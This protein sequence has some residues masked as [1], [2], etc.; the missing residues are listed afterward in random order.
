VTSAT[1]LAA[2][3]L[4]GL[5]RLTLG[6]GFLLAVASGVLALVVGSAQRRRTL[7]VLAIL[8][9]SPKQRA[10]FLWT[11][12]RA[13]VVAGVTAGLLAGGLVAAQL[14]KVL[15]GI[16][17]PAPEHPSVPLVLLGTLVGVV[18]TGSAVTTAISGRVLGRVE[19]ARLRDF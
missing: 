9:A 11:E 8:G 12:A 10:G 6:F 2:S 1:G 5:A 4:G 7:V 3:N 17:D 19:P 15:T 16:F 18:L 13:L 14:V